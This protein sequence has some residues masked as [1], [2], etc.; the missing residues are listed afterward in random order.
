MKTQYGKNYY[1]PVKGAKFGDKIMATNRKAF[2]PAI[3]QEKLPLPKPRKEPK[4]KVRDDATF[5][6]Q[7]MVRKNEP[8]SRNFTGRTPMPKPSGKAKYEVGKKGVDEFRGGDMY[9]KVGF[10]SF[11]DKKYGFPGLKKPASAPKD[12]SRLY[13][14][15][16]LYTS[17]AA[18]DP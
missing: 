11:K 3:K 4:F 6:D 8:F 1:E 7:I 10:R 15:C 13:E 17:D 2:E 18:D 16:L 9:S 12:A 5:G 14:P